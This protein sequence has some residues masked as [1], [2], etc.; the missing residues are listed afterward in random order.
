LNSSSIMSSNLITAP[1][2]WIDLSDTASDPGEVVTHF[3]RPRDLKM[4]HE[5]LRARIFD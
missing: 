1:I 3:E 4:N 5:R 2:I